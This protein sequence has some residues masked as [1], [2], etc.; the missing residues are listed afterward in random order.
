MSQAILTMSDNN[1][2]TYKLEFKYRLLLH[3]LLPSLAGCLITVAAVCI[4]MN[5]VKHNK[6]HFQ[7][8]HSIVGLVTVSL[9]LFSIILGVFTKYSFP[10]RNCVRPICTKITHSMI[11]VVTY[12]FAMA[13][14]G[15][16]IYSDF[17][18]NLA[19]VYVRGSL[20]GV[21]VGTSI[22]ILVKP[23]ALVCARLKEVMTR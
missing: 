14:I 9:T 11:G 17:F 16:G 3:W 4:F 1:Y 12:I 20:L 10:L 2:F 19:D 6:L 5:K 23:L 22:Y 18:V 13:T 15:L 8:T 7:T 21:L